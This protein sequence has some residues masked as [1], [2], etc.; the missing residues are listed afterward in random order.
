MTS[1]R[2]LPKDLARLEQELAARPLPEPPHALRGRVL[3][4]VE[5]EARA[6]AAAPVRGG[7]LPYAAAVAAL[8]LLCMNLSMSAVNGMDWNGREKPERRDVASQAREL[9]RVLPDLPDKEARRIARAMAPGRRLPFVPQVRGRFA[10]TAAR[11]ST[12]IDS[13]YRES[14]DGIRTTMD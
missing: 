2:S 13:I 1:E 6:P 10:W 9:Q 7:L 12:Q 8:L 5:C 3:A 4:A 11:E 14:N